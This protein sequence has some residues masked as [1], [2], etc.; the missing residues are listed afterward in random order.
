MRVI[1]EVMGTPGKFMW[2]SQ[3]F[4]S[5]FPV[6]NILSKN[7][8]ETE[9]HERIEGS[10]GKILPQAQLP[11]TEE[12]L[13]IVHPGRII[14]LHDNY[15]ALLMR[16]IIIAGRPCMRPCF[17]TILYPLFLLQAGSCHIIK[18]DLSFPFL[19]LG[20]YKKFLAAL[21]EGWKRWQ[22][23]KKSFGA[24]L[25]N[26]PGCL[27]GNSL[28]YNWAKQS[29]KWENCARK[30]C[31][32]SII[33]TAPSQFWERHQICPGWLVEDFWRD[34]M[35]RIKIGGQSGKIRVEKWSLCHRGLPTNKNTPCLLT[36]WSS[37]LMT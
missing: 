1:D 9:W 3:L 12:P 8:L 13:F 26:A 19:K 35:G 2:P 29:G 15:Q 18:F 36:F 24:P 20:R 22:I 32:A 33:L 21:V 23:E 7:F 31:F 17:D 16:R 10:C 34:I 5:Q 37:Q 28:G 30:S 4:H 6:W 11:H 27:P 25:I 14:G